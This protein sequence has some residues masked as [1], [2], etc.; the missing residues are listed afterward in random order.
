MD[1]TVSELEEEEEEDSEPSTS[2]PE[3]SSEEET[4]EFVTMLQER[5]RHGYRLAASK[6]MVGIFLCVWVRADVMPRVTG[7]RVSCVGRG[8]MGYM[9]NKG[10]ISISLTLQG[11]SSAAASTSLCFVCTH[12]ASGEKDGDEVRRNSD[13][14]EILKRTRFPRVHRFSRL[15]ASAP[16]S[17]E[18]ILEH[19]YDGRRRRRRRRDAG[20]AGAERVAGAAG[21]RPAARG[22]EGRARVRRRVGGGGDPVPAHV[23]VPCRVRHLRHGRTELLRRREAVAGEEEAHAGMVRPH[24]V[25]RRGRGAGVVRARRVALLRPPPRQL[26]LLRHR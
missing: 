14:A 18:T 23:Q 15:P 5:A 3:S 16:S 12:L 8:I 13:V 9:G 19:E 20:A 1:D 7:L 10:S 24:P 11:G 25:A 22:A 26:P 17:P 4:S 2:N 21:A 6:Q